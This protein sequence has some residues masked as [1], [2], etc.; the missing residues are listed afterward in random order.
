[1]LSL[2]TLII[3]TMWFF[4]PA[5]AANVAPVLATRYQWLPALNTPLDGGRRVG[6][7]RLLGDNKTVRGLVVGLIFGSITSLIQYYL[8]G[9]DVP[10]LIY[11][12][13]VV[14]AL[15]WGVLLG[16]GALLGDAL[17]SFLKRRWHIAPGKSWV[18][19]D[20]IDVVIGVL[21]VTF[22]LVRVSIAHIVI[23]FIVIGGVMYGVSVIGV[24]S[25]I[26]RKL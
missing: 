8:R 4:L 17:K 7:E 20:Q 14:S 3:E 2:G 18:P 9:V 13:S 26:K 6:K 25:G 15:G 21:L 23:A 22:P 24:Q 5:L 12:T 1:M 11:P 19:F 16:F 10:S